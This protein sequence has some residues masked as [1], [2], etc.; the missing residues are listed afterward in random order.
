MVIIQ[1]MKK[2]LMVNKQLSKRSET[3]S[4]EDKLKQQ[5]QQKRREEMKKRKEKEQLEKKKREELERFN[6]LRK[7][8][9]SASYPGTTPKKRKN[10]FRRFTVHFNRKKFVPKTWTKYASK[11][12]VKDVGRWKHIGKEPSKTK[13][14]Y[15][16]SLAESSGL[17]ISSM[18]GKRGWFGREKKG[19]KKSVASSF[20]MA[21]AVTSFSE[22][23]PSGISEPDATSGSR[24]PETTDTTGTS[25]S[26]SES[27]GTSRTTEEFKTTG[28]S[29]NFNA[30]AT[31]RSSGTAGTTWELGTTGD[32]GSLEI[33]GTSGASGASQ[34]FQTLNTW[35]HRNLASLALRSGILGEDMQ[36]K[37]SLDPN[38]LGSEILVDSIK[39]KSESE[40]SDDE[41]NNKQLLT[42][43]IHITSSNETT[44]GLSEND[45]PKEKEKKEEEEKKKEKG[46]TKKEKALPSIPETQSPADT[47]AE[48]Q[49]E[50][51]STFKDDKN[52][53]LSPARV[54]IDESFMRGNSSRSSRGKQRKRRFNGCK[55]FSCHTR[56][57]EYVLHCY[58]QSTSYGPHLE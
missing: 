20:I 35:K 33:A 37:N 43:A 8:S 4:S 48:N 24:T 23:K 45:E 17:G 27:A 38:S 49:K 15:D 10:L 55:L 18:L 7:M 11:E 3:R 42:N 5:Q 44:S 52:L 14:E 32:S 16:A 29:E 46:G 25:G 53:P 56:S 9:R 39:R 31:S 50:L 21:A 54:T 28:D 22:Y 41:K 26:T 19:A 1:A 34:T 47:P 51:S 12:S 58:R 40:S 36:T 30:S 13:I 2:A 6:R 57:D